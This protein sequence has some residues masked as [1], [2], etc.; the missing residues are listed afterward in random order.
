MKTGIVTYAYNRFDTAEGARIIKAHGYDGID[1]QRLIDTETELFVLDE[2]GFEAALRAEAAV[3]REAGLEIFQ[4]HGPWRYPPQDA[5]AE[6]RAE[7][8]EK[9]SRAVRGAAYLGSPYLVIHP[10]MPF[11]SHSDREPDAQWEI[12]LEFMSRLAEVGR[13]YGVTVC[14]ENMP[15]RELPLSPVSEI[16][17]MVKAVNSDFFG[18]CLDTG[19]CAVLGHSPADGVRLVGKK[20]LKAL[21][22]HDNGGERDSH[23]L[24]GTGVIDW[25]DFSASLKEIGFEGAVSIETGVNRFVTDGSD[26][27]QREREL[28][29]FARR[30]AENKMN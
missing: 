5:T 26:T 22:V 7:R 17:R 10:L 4:A 24:P 16:L 28:A 8:F 13:E 15:F 6:D 12:N 27:D 25:S 29:A 30:I 11:G 1:Y 14:F 21:H 23:W 18:V 3:Y 2:R 9:M 20:H 19:H